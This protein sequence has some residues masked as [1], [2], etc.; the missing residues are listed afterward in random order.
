MKLYAQFRDPRQADL[1]DIHQ[2]AN[3]NVPLLR[4][5]Q[6]W[7]RIYL[8]RARDL[9]MLSDTRKLT[10]QQRNRLNRFRRLH[11]WHSLW[12]TVWLRCGNTCESCGVRPMEELH[13]LHYQT[14]GNESP[15]DM[16]GLCR[17]CHWM[18]HRA[19]NDTG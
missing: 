9:E 3:D 13:H 15:E 8:A 10:Q 11:R 14:Y 1:P 17:F 7:A 12:I 2:P 5:H 16:Q 18:Y 6:D 19:S 4:R